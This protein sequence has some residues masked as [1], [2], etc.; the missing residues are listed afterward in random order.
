MSE[1][2]GLPHARLGKPEI[3]HVDGR[4]IAVSRSRKGW[5]LSAL[6]PGSTRARIDGAGVRARQRGDLAFE[7]LLEQGDERTEVLGRENALS[8]GDERERAFPTEHLGPL[9][10]TIEHQ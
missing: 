9:V 4:H 3:L 10:D 6:P 8:L 7:L 5:R 2:L 1:A